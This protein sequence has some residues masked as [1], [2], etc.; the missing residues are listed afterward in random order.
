MD[1]Y[2]TCPRSYDGGPEAF[3]RRL[4]E[5]ARWTDAAGCRGILIFDDNLTVDPWVPAQY[6]AQHTATVVPMVVV[7]PSVM[8]PFAA[9][10]LVSA[11]AHV[12]GRRIDLV[13][14]TGGSS[15]EWRAAGDTTDPA[16]RYDRL[17]E[18][19]TVIG[20]LFTESAAFG[21]HGRFY[22]LEAARL[23]PTL[24]PALIPRVFLAGSSAGAVA[25]ARQ[26]DVVRLASPR[27]VEEYADDLSAMKNTG[28]RIGLLARGT[29]AE[30]WRVAA[31][32]FPG[33]PV[34]EPYWSHP[35]HTY[36]EYCPYLVG[37]HTEVAGM[38]A[39]YLDLGVGTL[40]V[41]EPREE[42]DLHHALIAVRAAERLVAPDGGR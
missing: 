6:V 11:F 20:R 17:V 10:R 24:P 35:A 40:I 4:A 13:L 5:V 22:D 1:V 3:R 29:A 7:R 28:I 36:R 30:A 9:A 31:G 42:D 34:G 21:V 33:G 23:R 27:P 16:E 2:S 19:G 25:A 15:R 41:S 38:L 12:H 18:Y 8:P 37:S 26:L 39:R 32:R 14:A